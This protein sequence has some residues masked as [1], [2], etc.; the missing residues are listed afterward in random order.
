MD[1]LLEASDSIRARDGARCG[2][3]RGNGGRGPDRPSVVWNS[4]RPDRREHDPPPGTLD[5]TAEVVGPL[6]VAIADENALARQGPI[7]RIG[8]SAS[9]LR[10]EPAI[11]GGRRACHVSPSALEIEHEGRV[12]GDESPRDPD[13]GGEEV[14]PRDLAQVSPQERSPGGRPVRRGRDPMVGAAAIAGLCRESRTRG[15]AATRA[16]PWSGQPRPSDRPCAAWAGRPFARTRR[17]G[18]A[19]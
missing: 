12:V 8:Q 13:L 17:L 1:D 4:G 6:A 11:L 2:R 7:D 16:R 5:D 19:R 14:G 10:H 3:D 15:T 9:C 18:D